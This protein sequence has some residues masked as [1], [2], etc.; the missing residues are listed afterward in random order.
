MKHVPT[1]DLREYTTDRD[2]FVRKVGQAYEEF[3]FCCFTGHGVDPALIQEAYRVCQWFFHQPRSEKL[4]TFLQ[5][6][7]GT[8]G[9]TPFKVE[10]AKTS[11]L[12]DL[13]E[14]YHVGRDVSADFNPYP[15]ILEP[16]VWPEGPEGDHFRDTLLA[17]Y[18]A[19]ENLGRQVLKPL[20]VNIGL[21]EDHFVN[22]TQ[23]GNSILRELHYPPIDPKDLPAVRA[24]AH[25]DISLITLLVGATQAG[26]EILNRDGKWLPVTTTGDAIVVNV[27]DMMQR[28]TNHVYPS[29]T[30]RVVN[31]EG[32]ASGQSR[33]SIPFFMDPNPDHLI[34]TLP[35][36]ITEANPN[37]YPEP[38]TAHDYLMERL[39]E[40]KLTGTIATDEESA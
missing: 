10:T 40:I 27:G 13:K 36:T 5:G 39:A 6:K 28:M 17:L 3:G 4:K 15:D 23:H 20:A 30:H 14:F 22:I 12:A 35:S 37:R 34:Q 7:A 31:P 33:Y 8:R 24:E 18:A 1:L 26:L 19:L 25:E 11:N 32:Q 38:I 9:Y 2:A 16:N 29:T 21:P